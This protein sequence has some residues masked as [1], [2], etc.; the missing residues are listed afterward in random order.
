MDLEPS[1]QEF[2]FVCVVKLK[3]LKRLMLSEL[4]MTAAE[5]CC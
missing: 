5:L 2:V 4:F 3:P 1:G